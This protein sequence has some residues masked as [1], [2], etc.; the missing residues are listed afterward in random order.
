MKYIF[1]SV[2]SCF[3]GREVVVVLWYNGMVDFLDGKQVLQPLCF[4]HVYYGV[5]D[6]VGSKG[7]GII[8]NA[9]LVAL[10]IQFLFLSPLCKRC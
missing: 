9:L 8:F 10:K 5:F 2:F 6:N 4:W 7:I 1:Q 3:L